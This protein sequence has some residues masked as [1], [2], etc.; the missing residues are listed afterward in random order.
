MSAAWKAVV[1][2]GKI[3]LWQVY[4][5]WTAGCKTIDTDNSA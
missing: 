2:D 5:D 3:K 4:A 1:S